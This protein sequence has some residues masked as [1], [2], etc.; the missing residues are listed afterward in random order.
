MK[1][2][3]DLD[4]EII[5]ARAKIEASIGRLKA[6]A[7]GPQPDPETLVRMGTEL[8]A[9]VDS[10]PSS[11]ILVSHMEPAERARIL[12]DLNGWPDAT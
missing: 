5:E 12:S 11:W 1:Q 3:T 10:S 6:H 7:N 4:P 8:K 2:Y 9:L